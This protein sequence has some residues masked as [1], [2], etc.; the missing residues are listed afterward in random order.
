MRRVARRSCTA[1][2]CAKG[3]ADVGAASA[4]CAGSA[5][6]GGGPCDEAGAAGST[7]VAGAAAPSSPCARR[8]PATILPNL[9]SP[10]M[11]TVASSPHRSRNSAATE[12]SPPSCA[13]VRRRTGRGGGGESAVAPRPRFA[14]GRRGPR[15]GVP[16]SPP[17]T[18][19]TPASP[20]SNIP[21]L[22]PTP[23]SSIDPAARLERVA[24]RPGLG[25]ASVVAAPT[26]PAAPP[27]RAAVGGAT[28][29]AARRLLVLVAGGPSSASKAARAPKGESPAKCAS[30]VWRAMAAAAAAAGRGRLGRTHST[31]SDS[32]GWG[33]GRA[34]AGPRE[35]DG[36]DCGG[37]CEATR[38]GVAWEGVADGGGPQR[39]RSPRE[40]QPE[41]PEE[42]LWLGVGA[43]ARECVCV[44]VCVSRFYKEKKTKA[45]APRKKGG[46][47]FHQ[48]GDIAVPIAREMSRSNV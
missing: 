2:P 40:T 17:S 14:S 29:R 1:R 16:N 39:A 46:T 23:P 30:E 19:S 45:R 28:R 3:A 15:E 26:A 44:C 20:Q 25:A 34:E 9:P 32:S 21:Q 42:A 5:G 41:R 4:G 47:L 7:P 27:G 36:G 37:D 13:R 22:M 10:W 24:S 8:G 48:E 43:I 31:I 12:T 35:V 38:S 6:S 11:P 18:T 33:A